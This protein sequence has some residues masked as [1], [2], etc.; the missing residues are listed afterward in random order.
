MACSE[1]EA[2][3][4]IKCKDAATNICGGVGL[5]KLQIDFNR[6]VTLD[7][8][9]YDRFIELLSTNEYLVLETLGKV[10][11]TKAEEAARLLIKVFGISDYKDFVIDTLRKEIR[12]SSNPATLFRSSSMASK[13]LDVLLKNEAFEY[14]QSTLE[15]V[16]RFM[17]G[18]SNAKKVEIDPSR[19]TSDSDL[20][21]NTANLMELNI[22]IAD[23]IFASF[24]D[25]PNSVKEVFKVI[26]DEVA[27][28]FPAD[29]N[30]RYTAV[31]GFFFSRFIT[32]AIMNPALFKLKVGPQTAEATRKLLLI[33]KTLQNLSTFAEFGEKEAFMW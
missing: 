26:K 30:A 33:S 12:A 31:S 13:A 11:N 7:F 19:L 2:P 28:K 24:E 16:L 18:A 14:L 6:F 15:V 21:E 10:S 22:I 20:E 9:K 5:I 1:C 23:T 4:H 3:V 32:P 27:T 25:V 29:A 8:E 17:V